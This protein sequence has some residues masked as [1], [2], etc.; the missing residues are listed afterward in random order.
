MAKSKAKEVLDDMTEVVKNAVKI[1]IV[2]D[3]PT[4]GRVSSLKP[5]SGIDLNDALVIDDGEYYVTSGSNLPIGQSTGYF[6]QVSFH[7]G[8]TLLFIKQTFQAMRSYGDIQLVSYERFAFP[9]EHL[10]E[11]KSAISTKWLRTQPNYLRV[12]Y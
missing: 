1:K 6:T 12:D 8:D 10:V 4:Q 11:D 9:K 2:Q 7:D 5:L 3:D